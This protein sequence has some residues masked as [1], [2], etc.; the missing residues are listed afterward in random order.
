MMFDRFSGVKN[1]VSPVPS[2]VT[3]EMFMDVIRQNWKAHTS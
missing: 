1:E 3:C 2:I